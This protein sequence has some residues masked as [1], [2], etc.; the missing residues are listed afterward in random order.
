MQI[1]GYSIYSLTRL[2]FRRCYLRS[3]GVSL[4][5]LRSERSPFLSLK[6]SIKSF[7]QLVWLLTARRKI[8]NLILSFPRLDMISGQY[9]DKFTDPII[10]FSDIKNSYIILDHGRGGKH[11]TP[12]YHKNNVIWID[13]ISVITSLL[14]SLGVGRFRKRNEEQLDVFFAKV[15]SFIEP[16]SYNRAEIEKRLLGYLYS[17]Y[18]YEL[19]YKRL[20]V[21]NVFSVTRPV[22][23]LRA[24]RKCG[25]MTFELQH[26]I[27]YND[28]TLYSGF[29][30]E[31]MIPNYFLA[32]GNHEPKN[33][34]GINPKRIINIGW[35]FEEMVKKTNVSIKINPRDILVVSEPQVSDAIIAAVEVLAS[36][37]PEYRFYLRPHPQEHYSDTQLSKIAQLPNFELQDNRIN[38]SVVLYSFEFV[39]G[40]SSTVL[41]E[42]LSMGKK[43]GKLYMKGL[44]PK[45]LKEEDTGAFC[46]ITGS[47]DFGHFISGEWHPS[48][49][50][51]IY[52]PYD[53]NKLNS[54]IKRY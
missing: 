37:Y 2:D 28:T 9:M 42:A 30:D 10:D 51:S 43:V 4:M 13:S 24:A 31:E 15:N 38:I 47:G 32:F 50:M 41:Y 22:S 8:D 46:K 48:I 52:S 44:T 23:E 36:D 20:N 39:I 21:K 19:I 17:G 3:Q 27:T 11:E 25:A 45:Y 18:L 54:L 12:R 16:S 40:E 53:A 14:S 33:V 29:M 6:T 1:R 5:E 35:A 7:V 26:G 34:Y 49:R